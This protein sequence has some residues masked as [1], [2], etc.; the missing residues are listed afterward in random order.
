MR[1]L[2]FEI[3]RPGKTTVL[4]PEFKKVTEF[5]FD[6]NGVEYFQFKNPMDMPVLRYKKYEEFLGEA[7]MRMSCKEALSILDLAE[8]AIEKSKGTDAILLIRTMKYQMSQ[9]METD[10]FYRLFT[11]LFF[12]LEEDLTEY[13]YD[14][15][16]SKIKLFK[17][18]PAISFFFQHPMKDWL[19]APNISEQDLS[20]F[21]KQTKVSK[22]YIQRTKSS[23]LKNQ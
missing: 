20:I 18:Q 11:C 14:Y 9:F 7:E 1:L 3:R 22:E 12:D 2:G 10:T 21:L 8:D 13:D 6:I 23:Y 15:N 4:H 19:P 17:S 5:A 16:E